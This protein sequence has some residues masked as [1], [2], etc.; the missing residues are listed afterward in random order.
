VPE[1]RGLTAF[2]VRVARAFFDLESSR[3]F[4]LAGGAALIAREAVAR[5]TEDLDLFT[6]R[7]AGDVAA[8]RAALID[9]AQREGWTCAVERAVPGFARLLLTAATTRCSSTWRKTH[10]P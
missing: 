10:R 8:A 7:G 3:G 2:Q 6:S 5:G 4:C 1:R 9:L